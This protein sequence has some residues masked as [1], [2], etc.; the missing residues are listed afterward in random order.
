MAIKAVIFDI[1]GVLEV[2][3]PTGWQE[4]WSARVGLNHSDFASRLD[5]TWTAGELGHISLQDA[6]RQI[7]DALTLTEA[8]LVLFMD[9]LWVEY[10]G[11]LNVELVEYFEA[12]RPRFKTGI[13]SNGFVGA[14]EREQEA[15][16]F[17][18]LCDVV[19]Y[20]HEEGLKK[21]DARFYETVLRKLDVQPHEAVFLDDMDVCVDGAS[22]VGMEAVQFIGNEQAIS[23]LE[24]LFI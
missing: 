3:P 7:A 22:R 23:A 14:R 17:E 6:E 20:S 4:K 15:Y 2:T 16:G 11:S 13:L 8:E 10:L 5:A 24:A 1:G 12:L 19:T 18:D 21:P 9:D